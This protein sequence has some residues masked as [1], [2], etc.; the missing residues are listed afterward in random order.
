[1]HPT[2]RDALIEKLNKV[3]LP[4]EIVTA[5]VNE[6]WSDGEEDWQ[7]ASEALPNE[8]CAEPIASSSAVNTKDQE[9]ELRTS[10]GEANVLKERGND[11]FRES[12]WK[13][14]SETYLEGLRTLP[15]RPVP[16]P[17]N[18]KGKEKAHESGEDPMEGSETP[19]F[20]DA[21]TEKMRG[22]TPLALL[23]QQCPV[24]RSILNA[25]IA[26]C[27][28]KL[29]DHT[30]AVQSCTDSL[31]D[32]PTYAKALHR[33]ATSNDAIGTWSSLSAAEK[34]YR[35]LLEMLPSSSPLLPLIRSALVT[36]HPR[37]E[38]A[39]K[40]ETDEMINKLKGLGDSFLGRFGMSTNN[41]QFTPNGQGGYSMNFVN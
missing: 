3:T 32:V 26:A 37:L 38:R 6:E 13:R 39:Q 16:S 7:D 12:N 10:L 15:L 24:I 36:L 31:L 20:P 35:T 9:E 1:M 11:L 19:G 30:N 27:H 41:F 4:P 34:D 33:R 28:V 22:L 18:V 2:S 40:A 23:E 29:G 5:S 8:D 21:E 25:N 14:A 17:S